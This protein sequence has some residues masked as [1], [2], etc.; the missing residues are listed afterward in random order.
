MPTILEL[1]ENKD[2]QSKQ[3]TT[4]PPTTDIP[5]VDTS[6]IEELYKDKNSFKFGTIYSDVK[7][8]TETFI[9]QETSGIRIK[10][11]VEI[12]N[13][14]IYGNEAGRITLRSTQISDEMKQAANGSEG[15]G[16][17]IGK[18]LDKLTGGKVTSLSG[19]RN[20]VNGFLQDKLGLPITGIPTRVIEKIKGDDKHTSAIEIN[21]EWFGGEGKLPGTLLQG[22]GGNLKTIGKQA[23]GKGIGLAKDKLRGA[24]FGDPTTSGDAAG[25]E[26]EVNYTTYEDGKTYQEQK[27]E[28]K[29]AKGDDLIKLLEKTKLDLSKVSPIYGVERKSGGQES[30]NG[31]FGRTKNAFGIDTGNPK[32]GEKLPTF[33]PKEGENYSKYVQDDSEKT[34][35][36]QRGLT[37]SSDTIMMGDPYTS[38]VDKESGEVTVDGIKV[39]D[40]VPLLIGRYKSN[41]YPM[42][43]FRCN[44]T[45]LT[46][47]SSPSWASNNFVGNPYKYYIFETVERSVSFNLQVYCQ[48]PLELANNWSKLSNLTKLSY[49][50]IEDNMAHPN[51][52]EFTL[53]DMYKGKVCVMDSLSYT[54]PDNGTW[55]TNVDGL[56]LPKF[57]DVN[58][59][60][61]FVENIEDGSVRGLYSYPKNLSSDTEVSSQHEIYSNPSKIEY[62]VSDENGVLKKSDKNNY[63]SEVATKKRRVIKIKN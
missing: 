9:E 44:I 63:N 5:A 18:G 39:R 2:F 23:L 25:R 3:L 11:A 19:V 55:E 58:M 14:L 49:P 53:G 22:G 29:N 13:P 15:G 61:K 26:P 17:L 12:N 57:V 32:K 46:E 24:L 40:L 10:S 52:V 43:A 6:T 59:T 45:G 42:M 21:S 35:L 38:T 1:F 56:L 36:I 37:N 34:T 20:K 28:V 60:L 51:F 8:D 50:L 47:T 48:N 54:I 62:F 30:G 7:A 33:S 4:A 41:T 31:I 16:G 27:D